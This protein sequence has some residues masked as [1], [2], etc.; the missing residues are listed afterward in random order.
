EDGLHAVI[1]GGRFG[2]PNLWDRIEKLSQKDE[3]FPPG[4]F[5]YEYFDF[6]A[7]IAEK[8]NIMIEDTDTL[9]TLLDKIIESNVD[10]DVLDIISVTTPPHVTSL[11][12][13]VDDLHRWMDLLPKK[14]DAVYKQDK[15]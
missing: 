8:N 9:D 4:M 10:I 11:S 3:Y 13:A 1:S 12:G 6:L 2:E 14:F 15:K 7:N 5:A